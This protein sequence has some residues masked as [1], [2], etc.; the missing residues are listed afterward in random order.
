MHNSFETE[1][2]LT[3]E[4][5]SILC[6]HLESYTQSCSAFDVVVEFRT[7]QLCRKYR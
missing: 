5:D 1:E 3:N 6:G 4:L 2:E 7:N